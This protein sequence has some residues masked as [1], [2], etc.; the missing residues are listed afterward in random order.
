MVTVGGLF[1]FLRLSRAAALPCI[2]M[3][4]LVSLASAAVEMIS[5]PRLRR[6]GSLYAYGIQLAIVMFF[7]SGGM[8]VVGFLPVP[9]Q[10]LFASLRA[11]LLCS[12]TRLDREILYTTA[13]GIGRDF[14]VVGAVTLAALMLGIA[15]FQLMLCVDKRGRPLPGLERES[16]MRSF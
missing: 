13:E 10:H 6:I 2:C 15:V 16:V 14:A 9:V 8:T 12:C 1:G 7:L 11:H 4:L 3:L 5:A